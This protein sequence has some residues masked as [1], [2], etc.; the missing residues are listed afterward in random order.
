MELTENDKI[1]ITAWIG[2]MAFLLKPC[3]CNCSESTLTE[4]INPADLTGEVRVTSYG[5][6]GKKIL[7]IQGVPGFAFT[8]TA[9]ANWISEEPNTPFYKVMQKGKHAGLANGTLKITTDSTTEYGD[10]VT[11]TINGNDV[12]SEIDI[13]GRPSNVYEIQNVSFNNDDLVEFYFGNNA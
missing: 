10:F 9:M 13:N 8:P 4:N 6:V 1:F 7:N 11:I 12:F 5:D 2:V 3:K